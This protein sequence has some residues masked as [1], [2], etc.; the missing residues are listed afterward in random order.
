MGGKAGPDTKVPSENDDTPWL[1]A[2]LSGSLGFCAM[3]SKVVL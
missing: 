2:W 1:S 3:D